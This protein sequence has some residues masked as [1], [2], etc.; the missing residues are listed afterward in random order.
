MRFTRL[1][2]VLVV[3]LATACGGGGSPTPVPVD[4]TAPDPDGPASVVCPVD[5]AMGGLVFAM[6]A[7]AD[8]MG[9]T[10]DDV[11]IPATAC[12]EMPCNWYE[13]PATGP[14]MTKRIFV[15]GARLPPDIDTDT[16]NADPNII[17]FELVSTNETFV[18]NQPTNF[19]TD[20]AVVGSVTGF[21]SM[22]STAYQAAAYLIGNVSSTGM[23]THLYSS[24]SGSITLTAAGT[25]AD[26]EIR[27]SVTATNFREVDGQAE[28]AGGCTG[29]L[30]GMSFAM[31]QGAAAA[32]PN[33]D[34][35]IQS[36]FEIVRQHKL[37]AQSVD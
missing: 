30:D 23:F 18:L 20:P 37:T 29:A 34:P 9:G 14:N 2:A 6:S 25:T 8:G 27:G 10:A 13:K 22:G 31:I 35:A 28:I 21:N 26:T 5:M 7:G 32:K 24:S 1:I 11:P 33:S 12:G 36:A 16:T 3:P 4:T 19:S 17:I 15:L